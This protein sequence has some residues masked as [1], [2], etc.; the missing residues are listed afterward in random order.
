MFA[1]DCILYCVG[2]NFEPMFRKIQGDLNRF[3]EW[4]PLNRLKIN[5]G[6]TKAMIVSTKSRL[7]NLR[8]IASFTIQDENI[9]YV[10]QYN[11]LGLVLDI[12]NIKEHVNNKMFVLHKI[13]KYLTEEAA[14][15]VYNQTIL[16][17][18]DYG[19]FLL[20]SLNS[21]DKYELQVVQNDALR[22]CKNIHMLDKISIPKL[23]DP[24]CLLSLEQRKV[25]NLMFIH[26]PKGKARS[27][28]NVNTRSQTKYVFK[29]DTKI[30]KKYQKSPFY[31]STIL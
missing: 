27:V 14:T 31:L 9:H 21:S 26:A 23:H 24:V 12:E 11:Y 5:S 4:C 30:G 2:N 13:R 8:N 25:L 3:I 10:T 29:T 17:I 15:M 1:D 28:T 22:F 19:G 20:I 6:K 18:F 16:L 7:N